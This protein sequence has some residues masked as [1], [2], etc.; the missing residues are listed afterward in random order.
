MAERGDASG[1]CRDWAGGCLVAVVAVMWM[2]GM[3]LGVF[4]VVLGLAFGDSLGALSVAGVML[5]SLVSLVALVWVA[6]RSSWPAERR[7]RRALLSVLAVVAALPAIALVLVAI[8][9]VIR[10]AG[11]FAPV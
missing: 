10:G 3:L 2:L 11:S 1:G 7:A 5:L 8:A 6:L 4:V 9:L